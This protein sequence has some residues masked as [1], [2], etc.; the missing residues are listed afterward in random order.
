MGT[1]IIGR[2]S[3]S[4]RLPDLIVKLIRSQARVLV[5]LATNNKENNSDSTKWI[6]EKMGINLMNFKTAY[7][8]ALGEIPNNEEMIDECLDEVPIEVNR[9][10]IR[11][12]IL[13]GQERIREIIRMDETP[14]EDEDNGM[15]MML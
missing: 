3:A 1:Y 9:D 8:T 15:G 6:K 10:F 13:N 5:R 11:S 12:F 14:S 2:R 7:N 4:G